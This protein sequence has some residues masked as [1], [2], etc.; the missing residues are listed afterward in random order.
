MRI[1]FLGTPEFAVP[2]LKM[3]IEQA[4]IFIIDVAGCKQGISPAQKHPCAKRQQV[5]DEQGEVKA[6]MVQ[7]VAPHGAAGE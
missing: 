7:D 1:A 3:L 5:P 6:E 4:E 2:S